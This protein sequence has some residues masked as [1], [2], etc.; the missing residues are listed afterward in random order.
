M[1]HSCRPRTARG[2]G[3]LDNRS[4]PSG[5][6]PWVPR[7]FQRARQRSPRDP[8]PL[9]PAYLASES[10]AEPT[11]LAAP[12]GLCRSPRT[13]GRAALPGPPR[14]DVREGA[15][16]CPRTGR[17]TL[18]Q[19][20]TCEPWVGADGEAGDRGQ[21]PGR[22]RLRVPPP[23]WARGSAALP[24]EVVNPLKSGGEAAAAAGVSGAAW[25]WLHG[26][27]RP[28][29]GC[30]RAAAQPDCSGALWLG[31]GLLDGGPRLD[32]RML[33]RCCVPGTRAPARTHPTLTPHSPHTHGAA[34]GARGPCPLLWAR[35]GYRL[36][37]P[38]DDLAGR[39]CSYPS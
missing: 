9:E 22:P 24:A 14:R 12:S 7:R 21:G 16:S 20:R 31:S 28:G 19:N 1:R 11:V 6:P 34:L 32:L 39:R 26:S 36:L 17:E 27:G 4:L 37:R 2:V 15:C 8:F 18:P 5:V 38:H 35:G 25:G 3:C 13:E 29:Q 10:P 30:V 23:G 33:S